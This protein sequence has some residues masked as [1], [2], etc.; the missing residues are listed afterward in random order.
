MIT[1]TRTVT[2]GSPIPVSVGTFEAGQ[3]HEELKLRT[4]TR[5]AALRRQ[6]Q[7]LALLKGLGW[8]AMPW[9]RR[10]VGRT[11]N[12]YRGKRGLYRDNGR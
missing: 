11:G 10:E 9:G 8:G 7:Q 12:T 1:V 4:V 3:K 6:K 5:M 2:L